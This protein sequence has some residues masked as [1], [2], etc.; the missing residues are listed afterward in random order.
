[1]RP[2]Y[3]SVR[4]DGPGALWN[5]RDR[6][7]E[8][9]RPRPVLRGGAEPGLLSSWNGV[10]SGHEHVWAAVP[11]GHDA[12]WV[13]LSGKS[14][15]LQGP[16][17]GV[18]QEPGNRRDDVLPARDVRS[19]DRHLPD[20]LSHRHDAVWRRFDREADLLRFDAQLLSGRSGSRE[21]LPARDDVR[22]KRDGECVLQA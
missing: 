9:L 8:L 17:A 10:Q 13:R 15:L 11:D 18:L 5:H 4:S 22:G 14:A 7:T 6:R 20:A 1:V 12:V 19:V 2:E 3:R 21:V 16:D